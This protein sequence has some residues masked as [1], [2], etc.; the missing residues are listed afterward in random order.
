MDPKAKPKQKP[1]QPKAQ[2]DA[3]PAPEAQ[4]RPGGMIGEGGPSDGGEANLDRDGREGGMIGE[5]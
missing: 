4:E 2:D 3:P 1:A 5:G